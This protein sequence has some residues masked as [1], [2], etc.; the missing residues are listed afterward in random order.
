MIRK[1]LSF[2]FNH[3]KIIYTLFILITLAILALTM[4]PSQQ[5]GQNRLFQYD[6]IGHFLMF[7]S[8]TLIFGLLYFSRNPDNANL[9]FILFSGAFFGIAIEALQVVLPFDRAFEF[10]DI[11]ADLLGAGAATIVLF[12]IK[13]IMPPKN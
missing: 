2:L 11:I 12:L 1:F 8:W 10:N 13:K 6:K 9:G 4:L 5:L 7:F 3:R